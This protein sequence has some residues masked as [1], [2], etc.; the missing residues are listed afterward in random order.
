MLKTFDHSTQKFNCYNNT[1]L[2]ES[3]ELALGEKD[4]KQKAHDY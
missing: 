4:K 2:I 1:N 3:I